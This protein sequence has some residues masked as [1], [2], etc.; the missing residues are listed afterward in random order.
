[1][2]VLGEF[3]DIGFYKS[4]NIVNQTYW[5]LF[6]I[7]HENDISN[8][9]L[10]PILLNQTTVVKN[11]RP[12]VVDLLIRLVS[13]LLQVQQAHCHNLIIMK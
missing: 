7:L 3:T 6:I 11:R 4:N 13:P 12:S 2:F 5:N 9:D 1:M 10:A 8:Y